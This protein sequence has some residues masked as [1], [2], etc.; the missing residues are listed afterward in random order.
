MYKILAPRKFPLYN[1]AYMA[2]NIRF[3][4]M[5][6][7]SRTEE[8]PSGQFLKSIILQLFTFNLDQHKTL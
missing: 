8:G 2:H 6:P 7:S 4:T 3:A 1:V 5:E